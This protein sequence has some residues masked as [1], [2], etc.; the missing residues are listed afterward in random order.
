MDAREE[1]TSRVT[2]TNSMGDKEKGESGI[3]RQVEEV[4]DPKEAKNGQK[5]IEREGK[6]VKKKL[7]SDELVSFLSS[8]FLD[9]K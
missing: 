9:A 7:N 3:L 8:L 5:V 1:R 2:C 4:N 6:E